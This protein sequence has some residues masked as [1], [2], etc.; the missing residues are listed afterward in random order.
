MKTIEEHDLV[1]LERDVE[2]LGLILGDI[3]T[4]V[5]IYSD[6]NGFE[7][8]F[9]TNGG[10]SIAVLKLDTKDIRPFSGNAILHVRELEAK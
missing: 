2:E 9:K 10:E 1:V 6:Q 3:G 7:V 5:G 4:V 8:E